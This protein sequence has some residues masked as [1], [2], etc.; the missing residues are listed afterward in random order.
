MALFASGCDSQ[1]KE[2][3][4]SGAA[5]TGALQAGSDTSAGAR[6]RHPK[7]FEYVVLQKGSGE[8]PKLG[9]TVSFHWT[10]RLTSGQQIGDTRAGKKPQTQVLSSMEL[11]DG[12]LYALLDMAP[13]ERRELFVPSSLAYGSAGH[14]TVVPPGADLTLDVELIGV[15]PRAR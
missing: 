4:D 14:P 11:I 3:V 8:S 2:A 12:L 10:G 13:G 9:D 1:D 15:E 6:Q 7:G 5:A